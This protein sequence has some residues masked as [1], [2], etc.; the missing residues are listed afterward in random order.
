MTFLTQSVTNTSLSDISI[1][2]TVL[3]QNS[4]WVLSGYYVITTTVSMSS[5]IYAP[6]ITLPDPNVFTVFINFPNTTF[7]FNISVEAACSYNLITVTHTLNLTDSRL[8]L[9]TSTVNMNQ[10]I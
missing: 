6:T 5:V 4:A 9:F 8:T 3:V 7:P 1:P 10:T 2:S